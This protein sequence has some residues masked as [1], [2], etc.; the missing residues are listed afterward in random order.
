MNAYVRDKEVKRVINTRLKD[1]KILCNTENYIKTRFYLVPMLR[2]NNIYCNGI[3][4]RGKI[5]PGLDVIP[6]SMRFLCTLQGS[7]LR[8][9]YMNIFT[10]RWRETKK[11]VKTV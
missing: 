4:A 1:N 2:I 3:H 7:R 11:I 5:L 8:I 10:G 9:L 6:I